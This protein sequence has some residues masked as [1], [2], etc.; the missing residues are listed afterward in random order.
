[1]ASHSLHMRWPEPDLR[2]LTLLEQASVGAVWLPWDVRSRWAAFVAGCRKAGIRCF[3]ELGEPTAEGLARAQAAGFDGAVFP[4]GEEGPLRELLAQQRGLDLYVLLKPEQ[5]HW[6]IEPARAVL[7]AGLWPGSRRP[8]P[9]LAGATQAAWLDANSYLSAWLRGLFPEREAILGYR[10]DEEAGIAKDQRVPYASVELALAEAAAAGGR[11]VLTLPDFYRKE[12]LA[13]EARALEAWNSLLRTAAFLGEHA[14]TFS[15]PA[16]SRVVVA[17]GEFSDCGEILNLLFRHSVSPAVVPGDAIPPFGEYRILVAVGLAKHPEAVRAALEF[18]RA[19]GKVMAAPAAADEPAWW[20]LP[21]IR[22]TASEAERESYEFGKGA[23]IAYRE[24]VGDPGEFALD[25]VDAMGWRTRDLRLWGTSSVIG[26]LHRQRG[27]ISVELLNYGG[28][29]RDVLV[30]VEGRFTRAT[31]RAP[32]IGP[33]PL[34]A[35]QYGTGTE[36]EIPGVTRLASLL[37]E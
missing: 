23:I 17:A 31:L 8:D 25:V 21:G 9:S 30:R 28:W 22:K 27:G 2:A 10:P 26:L 11:W 36:V 6:R 7:L 13:G 18:A 33:Q 4:A 24:P 16:A 19:G 12:L 5:I 29:A 34:R 35:L 14:E 1:M 20:R 3:A 32:G 37:L 15:R